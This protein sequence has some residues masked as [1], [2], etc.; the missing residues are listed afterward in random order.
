[1]NT[2]GER[3]RIDT[4]RLLNAGGTLIATGADLLV[5]SAS[6]GVDNRG[7]TLAGNGAL[8]LQSGSLANR[9]GTVQAAGDAASYIDVT[10]TLDNTDGTLLAAGATTI[11]AGELVNQGGKV[12]TSST[13]GLTVDVAGNLDN[14]GHGLVASAGKAAVT[15]AA[16]DNRGGAVSAAGSLGTTV[17]QTLDNRG[18]KLVAAQDLTVTAGTLDNR[19]AGL[20]VSSAGTLAVDTR[21]R[22]E[23]AGG[24][25]Q[26]GDVRLV[27]TGLGNAGGT[28]LGANVDVDTRLASLDNAG[29]TLAGTTGTLSVDSGA[30]NNAGGL[31]Q[32]ARRLRVDT[33]GQALVSTDAGTT[34]G[35]LSGDTLALSSGSLNNRGGVVY[36]QG[37]LVARTGDID[38]SA[39]QLGSNA[40]VDIAATTLSNGGGR[41]Q[42]G[43]SLSAA[44]SGVA[45]NHGGLLV[46]GDDLNVNAAQILNRD[47]QSA[48]A[49]KPLG[50]Q[51]DRLVLSAD[52]VDNSAGTLAADNHIGIRGA[53][54]GSVLDN[55]RGTVTSG[56]SIAV[57]VNRVLNQLGTLLAGK[58]LS[59][60]ADSLRGDGSLLSR[61]DLSLILQQDF[62]SLRAIT[63]N[64]RALIS[65][66]GLLANHS[67]LQAGDLEVRAA[68]VN[69]TAT[70][71][72][73]G[74]RTTVVARDTLTQR[75]LIDGSQTHIEAGMLDNVGT[76]RIY[77]DHLAI[78][79]GAVNNREEGDRA[80]VIAA[81]QRLDIGASVINNREQALIFSA[82]G[83]S[84]ALNIGGTL[85]ANDQATG[86]A[87]LM[88]NDSAT[89]ESLGGL[90]LDTRRLL[91]RNLHFSTLLAQVG[92]PT[93]YLYIQPQGDPNRH[94]ADEYRW[95]NW[96]RAGRYIHKETG[97]EVRAW[98][99][100][101]VTQT[102]FATQ[103]TE[104]APSMIR[105][106]SNMTLRGDELVNDKS[107]IIAGGI[108]QGDLDRLNN[109]AAFGEHITRQ[110]GTSQYTYNKWR[111]GFRRYHQRNWDAKIA[112]N[113]ADIV[114]TVV[115]D[116]SR[117]VQNASGGGS[118]YNVGDRQT[119][120]VGGTV[121]GSVGGSASANGGAGQKQITEVQVKVNG[122]SAPGTATG[123]QVSGG[124]GPVL[125]KEQAVAG[126]SAP[127][128][129][130]ADDIRTL[131]GP[132]ASQ[133][134]A[135]DTLTGRN[136]PDSP[137]GGSV[138]GASG[139]APMVIRTVQVDTGV[140]ANSLFRTV[141]TAGGYLIETDPRFTDYRN[142]LSSDYM[143]ARLGYD[144]AS[145][146]KRLGDGFYEQQLVRDQIGQLTGRRFLDG[147]ADDEAQY[148]ALLEAGA[149]Y[150]KAWNLRPG[151]ALS[152][153]Q[154]AQLT[155]DIV[156]LVER[157]VMLADGTITRA[158]VPQVYVRVK[159]GD[160]DGHG[161][162]IAARA[163]DLNLKGDL[164]NAG[165]IAGRTAVKLTGESLRNLG[166]GISGEALALSAR[167]DIDNIGGA[168]D[169]T[170]TLLL[171]A[172]RDLNVAS[173]TRS[174]ASQAG[175]SDFSRTNLDRVAGL[176]VTSPGG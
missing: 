40:N 104:S 26:G 151:V 105:A 126:N 135:V 176:Y 44:L 89:I 139:D 42:A 75:G 157:D 71:E 117:V 130:Q 103:I 59:V 143:L 55:T 144:P 165:T 31:L 162:L 142:W 73:R 118:G 102:E 120:Q 38:N 85:D 125:I 25:L 46:A 3:I 106:G 123:G 29:G 128:K 57:T 8:D 61:G 72:M 65:T 132:G 169:A 95:E 121:G 45:D 93:T 50:L 49:S 81:R 6:D 63:V 33:H 76:G 11:K 80:A 86:R 83:G 54:A 156:W 2:F 108:L 41:V 147:Y 111:G 4:G 15:A 148:R 36:S 136:G 137:Q 167:N 53:G 87:S 99:Q 161:T 133:G 43:Q 166:G 160:L 163:V 62:T 88:L 113:P 150:A 9:N 39:G 32:S 112:Y 174:A 14:R 119:A 47:T 140:P 158:L 67:L 172:G 60:T 100:F 96:S 91:N 154:M 127:G 84:D 21:D 82:G 48:D 92:G 116:V 64:G 35:I 94:N 131:A 19:D 24:T 110:S 51:G 97:A 170:S 23:N 34:G 115:L 171:K 69:N 16:L 146:H 168:L 107:Q 37:D 1:G 18:G 58:S 145:V 78:K 70:G 153:A 101:E 17:Q 173:T 20:V 10:R 149:T 12:Q 152:A 77:G 30:L 56:G 68:N 5:V 27:N 124:N 129:A 141:P 134:T 90:T 79:G 7:G 159:P 74:G 114:E 155:S 52:R 98:T 122:V 164:R 22:T 175:R 66:A 138:A 28:V 13:A 109:V